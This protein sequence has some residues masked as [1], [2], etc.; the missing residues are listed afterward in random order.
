MRGKL[1]GAAAGIALALLCFAGTA[2]A[3]AKTVWT[4][5]TYAPLVQEMSGVP[6]EQLDLEDDATDWLA[7][8]Q[9][10]DAADILGF[11]CPFDLTVGDVCYHRIFVA[12]L[13]TQQLYGTIPISTSGT[14]QPIWARLQSGTED[15]FDGAMAIMTLI[16]EAYHNRLQSSDESLVN[17]C[18]LRDFGYWLSKDFQVPATVTTTTNVQSRQAHRKRTRLRHHRRVHGRMRTWYTH[19][20]VTRYRTVTVPQTAESPN[21]LYGTLVADAEAFYNS[22]PPPYNAGTCTAPPVS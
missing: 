12:P 13:V 17:T 22:Q 19:K 16:H 15:P 3:A 7:V 4:S 6:D 10:P 2:A 9:S 21:P 1:L 20:W 18:A 11:T 5:Q 8:T 14:Y